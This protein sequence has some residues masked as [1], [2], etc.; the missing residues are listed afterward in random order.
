VGSAPA[1]LAR[2]DSLEPQPGELDDA[3]HEHRTRGVG[4]LVPPR[5]EAVLSGPQELKEGLVRRWIVY[6]TLDEA[7]EAAGL[8]E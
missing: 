2:R 8:S 4:V 3:V 7:L 5:G 1:T 6:P